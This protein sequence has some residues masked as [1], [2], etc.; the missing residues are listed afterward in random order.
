ML[1]TDR[2]ETMKIL[3]TLNK[4]RPE[5]SFIF[6]TTNWR[7]QYLHKFSY[8]GPYCRLA[9][10]SYQRGLKVG[11]FSSFENTMSMVFFRLDLVDMK[12]IAHTVG[13]G[14]WGMKVS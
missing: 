10:F 11:F 7:P 13:K 14:C 8:I 1:W 4:K 2:R 6:E 9:L 3:S 12:C 5:L